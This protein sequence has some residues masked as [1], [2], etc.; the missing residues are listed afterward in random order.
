VLD[1]LLPGEKTAPDFLWDARGGVLPCGATFTRGSSGWYFNSAGVLVQAGSNVAR[2]EWEPSTLAPL[3][4][5]A[6]RQSTNAVAQSQALTATG[7]TTAN[8]TVTDNAQV[9]PDGTT[10][11]S[12]VKEDGT[13]NAHKAQYDTV[14]PVSG[15]VYGVSV[16]AKNVSGSRWLQLNVSGSDYVNFQP[17]T[18]MIG[19]LGSANVSNAVARQLA[20]GWWRFSFAYTAPSTGTTSVRLYTANA[21]NAVGGV[22]YAGDGASTIAVWGL[23]FESASAGVTSYIPTSGSAVTRAADLLALPLASLP[24]W[25]PNAGGVLMAIYRLNTIPASSEQTVAY[26]TDGSGNLVD[27]RAQSGTQS[28]SNASGLLTRNTDIIQIN[29]ATNIVPFPTPFLRRKQAFG[30]GLNR[31]QIAIDG[32]TTI[33]ANGSYL[34]PV[35]MTTLDLGGNTGNS[36]T[37]T[38]ERIAYY[39]SAR[40]DGFVQAVTQ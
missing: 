15:S 31:G 37:G 12:T 16:F 13:T 34:L 4:Y 20:N 1:L 27:C 35:R 6:E 25:R 40:S 33:G 17:S 21:G 9:A 24:G 38:L 14:S 19:S 39:A 11:A 3:G 2:F 30:W 22:S 7:W 36:L 26:F 29:T 18:G 8:L 28:G 32:V 10:R 23:Q 5:L